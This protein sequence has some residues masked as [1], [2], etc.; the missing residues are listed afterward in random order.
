[1]WACVRVTHPPPKKHTQA[2][3]LNERSDFSRLSMKT[4]LQVELAN[5]LINTRG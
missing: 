2:Q 3:D 4:Q 1:V 5:A